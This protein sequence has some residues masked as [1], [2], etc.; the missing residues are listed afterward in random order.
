MTARGCFALM[1][2]SRE[3]YNCSQEPL[4]QMRNYLACD[5]RLLVLGEREQRTS[6]CELANIMWRTENIMQPQ[7][8]YRASI[9]MKEVEAKG[10]P[11]WTETHHN[12]PEC[13][14]IA[15]KTLNYTPEIYNKINIFDTKKC[16]M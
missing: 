15:L 11:E 16:R 8:I 12:V 6:C 1:S 14:C 7:Y 13:I 2:L 5:D 4:G 10:R 3:P 9:G